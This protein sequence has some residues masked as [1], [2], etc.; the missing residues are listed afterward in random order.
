M[1]IGLGANK[2]YIE[3]RQITKALLIQ[4]EIEEQLLV[5]DEIDD[6]EYEDEET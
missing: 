4:S 6:K 5:I 2:M 3:P 1:W